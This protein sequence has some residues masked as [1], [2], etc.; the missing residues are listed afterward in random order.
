MALFYGS[1]QGADNKGRYG[2]TAHRASSYELRSIL[3]SDWSSMSVEWRY[4]KRQPAP[5]SLEIKLCAEGSNTNKPKFVL[6]EG[7][8]SDFV[9]KLC[10][11]RDGGTDASLSPVS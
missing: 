10:A 2:T 6:Y 9:Q 1:V 3:Q 5:E 8:F 4:S 11:I 7:K